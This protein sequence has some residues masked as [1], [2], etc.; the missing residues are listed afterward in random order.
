[1]FPK[2]LEGFQFE[3]IRF[4]RAIRGLNSGLCHLE[5]QFEEQVARTGGEFMLFA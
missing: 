3:I 1:V 5:L 4:I 2:N